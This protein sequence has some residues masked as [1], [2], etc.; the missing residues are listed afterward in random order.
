MKQQKTNNNVV[1]KEAVNSNI[2]NPNSVRNQ[3]MMRAMS[4]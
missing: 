1:N 4:G 2:V 3:L